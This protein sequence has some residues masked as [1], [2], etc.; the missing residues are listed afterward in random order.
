MKDKEIKEIKE[1]ADYCENNFDLINFKGAYDYKSLPIC[2]I[3]CIYSLRAKYFA[4][5]VPVTDRYVKKYMNNNRSAEGD[6]LKDFINRVDAEGGCIEFADNV[7]KNKQKLVQ[8][9]KS[10]ICYEI[11]QTLIGLNVNT[12]A[13][14]KAGNPELIEKTV[15]SIRG[16]GPAAINYLF[17]LAGDQNRCKPDVHIHRCTK[18]ALGKDVSDNECQELCKGAVEILKINY[19]SLTVRKLDNIIWQVYQSRKKPRKQGNG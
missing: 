9:Y 3:D 15:K 16:V 14:F 13:E 7:L 2:L 6:T 5:C 1:F 11:A 17:M 8:R 4:V 19:P 18:D 10:E 12:L